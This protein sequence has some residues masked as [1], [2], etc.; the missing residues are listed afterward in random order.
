MAR[1]RRGAQHESGNEVGP[2]PPFEQPQTTDVL[3]PY[4]HTPLTSPP[5]TRPS[6][7]SRT[8]STSASVAVAEVEQARPALRPLGLRPQPPD[9]LVVGKRDGGVLDLLDLTSGPNLP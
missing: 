9:E 8:R 4:R 1:L 2:E 7:D 6:P 5:T 3:G